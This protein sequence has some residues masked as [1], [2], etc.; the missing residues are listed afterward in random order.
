MKYQRMILLA[1]SLLATT[2]YE[3]KAQNIHKKNLTKKWKLSTYKY[4]KT[5]YK[6]SKQE[7]RDYILLKDDLTYVSLDKGKAAT[8][9][10]KL[11]TNGKFIRLWNKKGESIRF[12]IQTL[13]LNRLVLKAD[14]KDMREIDIHYV[15]TK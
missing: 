3:T 8:G 9:K 4:G 2:C 6:P 1:I 5:H 10:W 7:Q 14:L 15:S 12:F 11:N 13:T